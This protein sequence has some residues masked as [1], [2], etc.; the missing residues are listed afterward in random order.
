MSRASEVDSASPSSAAPETTT[1]EQDLSGG[2]N[3]RLGDGELNATAQGEV[4]NS[5]PLHRAGN[6][7]EIAEG[8]GAPHNVP[9]REAAD[10]KLPGFDDD[11]PLKD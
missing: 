6:A 2:R 7:D 10:T 5:E 4:V 3:H 9:A 11:T 1:D 8:V